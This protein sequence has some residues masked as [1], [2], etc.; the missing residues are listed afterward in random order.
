MTTKTPARKP[1]A[2]AEAAPTRSAAQIGSTML[3][4][5][6]DI[7]ELA[8]EASR[9]TLAI[10]PLIGLTPRDVAD[11]ASSLIKVLSTSPGK[12][13]VHYGRYLEEL[14]TVMGGKSELAPDRKS[15]V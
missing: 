5:A 6:S 11:A 12:T 8:A 2:T 10:N 9:N 4:A 13:A 3:A 1:H 7:G 15:V 14:V